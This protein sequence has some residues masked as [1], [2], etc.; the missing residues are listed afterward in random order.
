MSALQRKRG[1]SLIETAV[2]C[3]FLIPIVLGILDVAAV[4]LAQTQN[5]ALAKHACRQ[6]ANVDPNQGSPQAVA[7]KVINT[8]N[9]QHSKSGLADTATLV[10]CNPNVGGS[11]GLVYV[12]TSIQ[13][14]LPVPFPFLPNPITLNSDDTEPIVAVLAT[15]AGGGG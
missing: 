11:S 5:D 1:A 14:H 7:T 9:S 2:G 15:P 12:Q 3:I 13:C 10:Q 4:A 8:F 6:A